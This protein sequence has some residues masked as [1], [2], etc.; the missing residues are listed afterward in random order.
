MPWK[1]SQGPWKSVRWEGWNKSWSQ[2]GG[3]RASSDAELE[4][5]GKTGPGSKAHFIC[6]I[7]K[8]MANG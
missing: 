4:V 6:C 3:L 5:E 2:Q 1:W 8:G 7:E